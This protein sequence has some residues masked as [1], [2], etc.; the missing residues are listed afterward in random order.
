MSVIN[1]LLNK[2]KLQ[3]KI[4]GNPENRSF[5]DYQNSL[6]PYEKDDCLDPAVSSALSF[7]ERK[8]SFGD[9]ACVSDCKNYS[10]KFVDSENSI[11]FTAFDDGKREF[12]V[13]DPSALINDNIDVIT[14]IY[15]SIASGD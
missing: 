13:K 4:E 3:K 14:V 5:F 12:P 1:L 11:I 6:Y 15:K 10:Y 9:T 8:R 7:T 2:F